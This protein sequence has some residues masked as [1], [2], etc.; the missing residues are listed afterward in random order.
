MNAQRLADLSLEFF[1][2]DYPERDRRAEGGAGSSWLI[3]ALLCVVV[4]CTAELDKAVAHSLKS[5]AEMTFMAFS[6]W[7]A[8]VNNYDEKQFLII[9]DLRTRDISSRRNNASPLEINPIRKFFFN[10]ALLLRREDGRFNNGMS[11]IGQKGGIIGNS[12]TTCCESNDQIFNDRWRSPVVRH[13]VGNI[14]PESGIGVFRYLE[15]AD[16]ERIHVGAMPGNK[17]VLSKRNT[18]LSGFDGLS[19]PA[20]LEAENNELTTSNQSQYNSG[21]GQH[22]RPNN[23]PPFV[24]RFFL[25]IG[26]LLLCTLCGFFGFQAFYNKRLLVGACWIAGG[27]LIGSGGMALLVLTIFSPHYS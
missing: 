4:F 5:P 2:G 1:E 18:F 15:L 27:I 21:D 19:K 12:A 16:T 22:N 8:V 25:A 11:G 23:E 3:V 17:F 26:S 10:L 13:A 20:S 7:P 24:R 14:W 6:E 9:P